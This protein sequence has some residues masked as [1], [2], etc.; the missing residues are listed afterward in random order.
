MGE[1][2]NGDSHGA[3]TIGVPEIEIAVL[4]QSHHSVFREVQKWTEAAARPDG[5]NLAKQLVLIDVPL[6][7]EFG[8]TPWQTL[9]TLRLQQPSSHNKQACGRDEVR[10]LD[11]KISHVSKLNF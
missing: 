1:V 4:V 10:G 3:A 5:I 8:S 6:K 9:L 11:V 7:T 2:G